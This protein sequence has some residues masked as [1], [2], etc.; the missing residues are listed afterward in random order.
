MLLLENTRFHVGETANDGELSAQ[1]A[2]LGDIFVQ[3]AFGV[4][5]R[6]QVCVVGC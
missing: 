6:D 2:A 4:V 3:D 5:H 1:L